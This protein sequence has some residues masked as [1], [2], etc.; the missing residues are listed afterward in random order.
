MAIFE[1]PKAL[2]QSKKSF[3]SEQQQAENDLT[4]LFPAMVCGDVQDIKTMMN[5]ACNLYEPRRSQFIREK[6]SPVI[7]RLKQQGVLFG[8]PLVT[9]VSSHLEKV[10]QKKEPFSNA[11]LSIM[12][13][14]ILL[15]QEILW[16]KIS[17]D[18]GEKG[19]KILK[20]LVKVEQ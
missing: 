20:R 17:G 14:D 16:K 7:H 12:K 13:N 10:L 15:L 8:Y 9:D 5:D 4:R 3:E 2:K 18:G 6:I 11:H 1:L 19:G